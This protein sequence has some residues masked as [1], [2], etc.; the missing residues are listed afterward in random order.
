MEHTCQRRAYFHWRVLER[1]LYY[2]IKLTGDSSRASEQRH[3]FVGVTH[4]KDDRRV[5]YA[6]DIQGAMTSYVEKKTLLYRQCMKSRVTPCTPSTAKKLDMNVLYI[7]INID[8]DHK[9]ILDIAIQNWIN[10]QVYQT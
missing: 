3:T 2:G 4:D 10:F 9:D 6:H 7:N 5:R 1:P 8:V